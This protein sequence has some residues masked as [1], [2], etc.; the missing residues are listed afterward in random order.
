MVSAE[1]SDIR[2]RWTVKVSQPKC[3][4]A[5]QWPYQSTVLGQTGWD[6]YT[7][8]PYNLAGPPKQCDM[9]CGEWMFLS[10]DEFS[11]FVK[12]DVETLPEWHMQLRLSP[13]ISRCTLRQKHLNTSE[14]NPGLGSTVERSHELRHFCNCGDFRFHLKAFSVA[15][16]L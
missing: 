13:C 12:S 10:L 14:S 7:V 11:C 16:R 9:T 5:I 3:S 2:S 1:Y 15:S 8:Y 4:S 6:K